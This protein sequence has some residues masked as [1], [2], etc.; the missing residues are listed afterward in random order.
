MTRHTQKVRAAFLGTLVVLSVLAGT[1]AFAG[2]AAAGSNAAGP[3]RQSAIEAGGRIEVTFDEGVYRDSGA[4][5]GLTQQDVSVYADGHSISFSILDDGTDGRLL[6]DTGQDLGTSDDVEV[7][8]DRVWDA[9]GNAASPG[10]FNVEE[11]GATVDLSTPTRYSDRQV[12]T[13]FAG[14][15]VAV[16]APSVHEGI[17]I[18]DSGTVLK[19]IYTHDHGKWYVFDTSN[20]DPGDHYTFTADADGDG[21][22]NDNV[23]G[24]EVRVRSLDLAVSPAGG[25]HSLTTKD[26]LHGTVSTSAG[27]RPIEVT[28]KDRGE[29]VNST[30]V[31]LNGSGGAS[32]NFG[33]VSGGTYTVKVE[34]VGSGRTVRTDDITVSKL[35]NKARFERSSYTEQR[36]DV[37]NVTVDVSGSDTATVTL[38]SPDAGY[39]ANVQVEDGN[40][41]GQVTLRW[42]TFA[43]ASTSALSLSKQ[44]GTVFDVKSGADDL[45]VRSVDTAVGGGFDGDVVEPGSYDLAVRSGTDPTANAQDVATI[46]LQKRSTD[47]LSTWTAPGGRRSDVDSKSGIYRS[48]NDGNLTRANTIARGDL[49]VFQL[50][51]SGVGGALD[52]FDNDPTRAFA[53]LH[54]AASF[55]VNATS[56]RA[57]APTPSWD[58]SNPSAFD[59]VRDPANDTYFVVVDTGAIPVE[60]G[61][62]G[63]GDSWRANFTVAKRKGG[64]AD[65]RQ[66][67]R[68]D[69]ETV[70]P[71]TSFAENPYNVSAAA[72]QT[73]GGRTTVAPG[74]ALTLHVRNSGDTSPQFFK[75]TTA[76]VRPDR[77]WGGQFNFSAQ[78]PGDSFE[79]TVRGGVASKETVDGSVR[80]ARETATPETPG[81]ATETSVTATTSTDRSTPT[82]T[83]TPGAASAGGGSSGASGGTTQ[84]NTPGFGVLVAAVALLAAALLAASRD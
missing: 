82:A 60:N 31:R 73:I 26:P 81:G 10:R 36:G 18:N 32:W 7:Y 24:A 33:R 15:K 65:S 75:R 49:V 25:D 16:E 48:I 58:F 84:Q 1:V 19:S 80:A 76:Y 54:G 79:A 51:A 35:T 55:S 30:T 46:T 34:D 64:L 74:T 12:L 78:S 44:K 8:V 53:E 9:A 43:A 67:V 2:S 41:D 42:N 5:G 50:Q 52:Y 61:D 13:T 68:T 62:I 28:L 27:G 72:N 17:R 63:D 83:A 3:K 40:G 20:L 4:S 69:F 57:N 37:V 66:V 29:T 6:L 21:N 11:T 59:V 39:T 56:V 47:G 23:P 70:D 14:T 45:T 38:G 77:T 71:T 22:F